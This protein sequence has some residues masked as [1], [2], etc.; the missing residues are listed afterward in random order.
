MK[1]SKIKSAKQMFV[2]FV[3]LIG[4]MSIM[5][6]FFATAA[7]VTESWHVRSPMTFFGITFGNNVFVAVGDRGTICRTSNEGR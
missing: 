6:P 7:I 3:S 1:L 2:M 4:A 5:G